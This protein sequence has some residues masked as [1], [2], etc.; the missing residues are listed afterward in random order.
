MRCPLPSLCPPCVC[1]CV[2]VNRGRP[3][4]CA[5]RAAPKC[6]SG[7]SGRLAGP[8]RLDSIS[9][10]KAWEWGGGKGTLPSREWFLRGFVHEEKEDFGVR[11]GSAPAPV[12][13]DEEKGTR[14]AGSSASKRTA[15]RYR[16]LKRGLCG[17]M[18]RL[19]SASLQENCSE[20]GRAGRTRGAGIRGARGQ[21]EERRGRADM[22]A[23]LSA[24]PSVRLS[25]KRLRPRPGRTE[26]SA[27]CLR[28]L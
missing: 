16:G 18:L 13:V 14:D 10:L 24:A 15:G 6:P 4:V 17:K 27:E 28:M 2:C 7:Q 1:V 23:A 8:E 19:P 11:R 20:C 25:P 3:S 5:P 12:P 9:W 21:G 26:E 22:S